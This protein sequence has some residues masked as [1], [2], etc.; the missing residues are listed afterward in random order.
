MAERG[1]GEL[2]E[3]KGADTTQCADQDKLLKDPKETLAIIQKLK[4]DILSKEE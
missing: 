4:S 3:G 2:A 1:D